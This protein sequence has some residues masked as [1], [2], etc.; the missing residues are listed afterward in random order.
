MSSVGRPHAILPRLAFGIPYY[1]IADHDMSSVNM[2]QKRRRKMGLIPLL[3]S[4]F[5]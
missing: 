2:L 3:A 1:A 5:E 4:T